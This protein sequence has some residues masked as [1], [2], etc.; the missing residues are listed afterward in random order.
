MET[1]IKE[2]SRLKFAFPE[3]NKVIKFD[4]TFFFNI[5]FHKLSSVPC[6]TLHQIPA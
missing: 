2:E 5:S 3:K 4:A 1:N 6:H